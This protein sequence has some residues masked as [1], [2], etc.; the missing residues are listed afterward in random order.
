VPPAAWRV[1]IVLCG[2]ALCGIG[3]SFIVDGVHG[4]AGV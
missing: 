3:V 4:I 2:V 1:L